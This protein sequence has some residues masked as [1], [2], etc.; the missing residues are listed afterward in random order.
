MSTVTA[1]NGRE[2]H[3]WQLPVDAVKTLELATEYD[4]IDVPLIDGYRA[5]INYGDENGLKRW[6]IT[7][8]TIAS[9]GVLRVNVLGFT[10]GRV[11][12]ERYVRDVYADNQIT[13]D[14]FVWLWRGKYYFVDFEEQRLSMRRFRVQIYSAGLTLVERRLVGVTLPAPP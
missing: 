2:Y 11:D 10:K 5:G 6:T 4:T 3:L 13:G 14:P 12:R 7:L 8:P 1:S 9:G